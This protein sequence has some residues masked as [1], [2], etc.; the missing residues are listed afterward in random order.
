MRM[1][2]ILLFTVQVIIKLLFLVLA[3]GARGDIK[4]G[5]PYFGEVDSKV[6]N[7]ELMKKGITIAISGP[8][9]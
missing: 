6:V 1:V 9:K 4:E 7:L 2:K 3:I 8:S 5:G